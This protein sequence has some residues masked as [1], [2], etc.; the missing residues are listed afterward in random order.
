LDKIL[1][2]NGLT[3]N[4]VDLVCFY[5]NPS[6]KLERQFNMFSDFRK[7][8]VKKLFS[9]F[10]LPQIAISRYFPSGTKIEY[11]NHHDSHL[12]FS[13]F[14]SEFPE[15][16]F[17]IADAVGEKETI[18]WG[19]IDNSGNIERNSVSFPHSLGMFY[20]T[21]TEFLGFRVNSDEY[22]VMGLA[23]SG[24]PVY[25]D[26]IDKLFI[27]SSL[28]EFELNMKYFSFQNYYH[29]NTFS[30]DF[31]ALLGVSRR[32]P[33]DGILQVHRDIAASVQ[34]CLER[35]MLK[36]IST[37]KLKYNESNHLCLGGGVAL[38]CLSNMHIIESKIFNEVYIPSSAGD[39]GSALG[40]AL[41]GHNKHGVTRNQ[42]VSAY[43]G[44]KQNSL[45]KKRIIGPWVKCSHE[46]LVE[47]LADGKVIGILSGRSEFGPRALGNRSILASPQLE[48]MKNKINMKIKKRENFRPFAPV[49]L[50]NEFA[51]YFEGRGENH[52]MTE[53]FRAKDIAVKVMPEAVHIDK[54]ARVQTVSNVS[55]EWLFEVLTCFNKKT[56]C[57]ALIN[58]SFNLSDEP[59]VEDELD[60]LFCFMRS[61]LDYLYING[62]ILCKDSINKDVLAVA[63]E[64]YKSS[65]PAKQGNTYSF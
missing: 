41:L 8:P 40:C 18:I 55:N 62:D 56:G 24:E 65:H 38:N 5:E 34:L 51:K 30:S 50:E 11:F 28:D 14:T 35:I 9:S 64:Y 48:G 16:S 3:P 12:A 46:R 6:I 1:F 43:L 2:D 58:T 20:S 21:F 32:L 13:F 10:E 61:E 15:S 54:T 57:P 45:K 59:I 23:A 42:R 36:F 19:H 53:V 4:D 60:A 63:N 25:V 33:S 49:I 22:K 37:I 27:N 39:A 31:E 17:L 7:I 52:Y 29:Q 26:M 44:P 47:Y